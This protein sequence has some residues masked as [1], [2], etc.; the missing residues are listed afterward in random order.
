VRLQK[1]LCGGLTAGDENFC[2]DGTHVEAEFKLDEQW[3]TS[4][5][6][7]PPEAEKESRC[8]LATT[9][10]QVPATFRGVIGEAIFVQPR[11]PNKALAMRRL[12][13]FWLLGQS[14]LSDSQ[15]AID[16]VK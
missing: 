5:Q 8:G 7:S 15:S 12:F 11:E 1:S 13:R 16:R 3:A 6:P 4:S 2:K 10:W 14:A 9:F